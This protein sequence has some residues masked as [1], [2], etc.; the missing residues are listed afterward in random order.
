MG[1]VSIL[2]PDP[3][4]AIGKKEALY[5]AEVLA[6]EGGVKM[7]LHKWQFSRYSSCLCLP[8]ILRSN[9]VSESDLGQLCTTLHI[10]SSI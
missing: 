4:K 1:K 8:R 3:G 10:G 7:Y 9:T 2:L 5:S 6:K